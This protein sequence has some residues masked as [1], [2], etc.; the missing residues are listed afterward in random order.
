MS[1]NFA[2]T[3]VWKQDYDVILWRHKQRTPNTK[4]YKLPYA[5]EWTPPPWKVSAYAT[6]R[7]QNSQGICV[8]Q[9][10]SAFGN[11]FICGSFR[12]ELSFLWKRMRYCCESERYILQKWETNGMYIVSKQVSVFFESASRVHDITW[13]ELSLQ[14][15]QSQCRSTET[16]LNLTNWRG[17]DV[18]AAPWQARCK[19]W[20]PSEISWTAERESASTIF[21]NPLVLTFQILK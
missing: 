10:L 13:K 20:A 18:R 3:L 12:R 8:N 14:V 9:L 1:T 5:T 19:K 16:N 15:T 21:G 6:D 7:L 2:K 11:D 17:A 4:K